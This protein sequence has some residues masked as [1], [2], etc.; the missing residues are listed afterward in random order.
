MKP[1][2]LVPFMA[3]TAVSMG[4]VFDAECATTARRQV[5]KTRFIKCGLPGCEI[6]HDHNGGYCCVGHYRKHKDVIKK[7]KHD[8]R[9]QRQS[10]LH[11]RNNTITGCA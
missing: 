10:R 5:E 3:Y 6:L 4:N 1:T 11:G 9:L 7:E 8:E 2:M